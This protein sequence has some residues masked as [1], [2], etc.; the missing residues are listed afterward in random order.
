MVQTSI[1]D[2][3]E[4]ETT[5]AVERAGTHANPKWIMEADAVVSILCKIGDDFT[6]DDVWRLLRETGHVT[7]EP[8]AL[9]AIMQRA[10]KDNYIRPAGYTRKSLRRE[11][12]RRPLTVWRPVGRRHREA[13]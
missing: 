11:C 2:Q 10:A 6:T 5:E 3:L 4:R 9:G 1:I 8:R 12:H 7:H 13:L